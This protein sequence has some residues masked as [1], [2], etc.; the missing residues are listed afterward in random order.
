MNMK[1]LEIS[2]YQDLKNYFVRQ[3]YLLSVYSLSSIIVWSNCVFQAHFAVLP[4]NV[5]V[6]TYESERY[7]E[8]R[9]MLMP[10][11]SGNNFS[12]RE[13]YRI[14]SGLGYKNIWFIPEDYLVG[15][16]LDEVEYFFEVNEQEEYEDYVYLTED[17]FELKGKRYLRKRNL[18]NQFT[19]EFLTGRHRAAVTSLHPADVPECLTFLEKW[20]EQRGCDVRKD[21]D[22]A[23]EQ[24]AVIN[25]LE[26]MTELE[27]KGILVRIDH[28]VSAFAISSHLTREMAILNFEKAYSDIKGLYQYLDHACASQLFSGYKY[29][30][31]ESDMSIPN[32][33]KSKKS[34]HPVLRVKSYRFKLR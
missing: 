11:S 8:S 29:T 13:L 30:N 18:I 33:A 12:P 28:R 3:P 19:Q 6:V 10:L 24:R 4:G 15:Q 1:R 9:H 26:N 32:L 14:A 16:E 17:L 22:L 27:M 2:D 7:P 25:A 23:C 5:L 34:Y 31:K 21:E 20:C